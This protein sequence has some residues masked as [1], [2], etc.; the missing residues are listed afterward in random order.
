M[1]DPAVTA[2]RLFLLALTAGGTIGSYLAIVAGIG[3]GHWPLVLLGFAGVLTNVCVA[4]LV[5]LQ[6]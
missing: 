4:G 2:L 5:A 6:K 1:V 3:Y